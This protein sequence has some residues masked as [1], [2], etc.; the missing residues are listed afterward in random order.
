LS[1]TERNIAIIFRRRNEFELAESYCQ[2]SLSHARLYQGKEEDKIGLVCDA[3]R[4]MYGLRETQDNFIDALPFAEEAYDLVAIAYNP[5][6]PKVQKA[7]GTLIE[8]L[9]HKGDLYNAERFA[10]ATLDSLKDPAN[11]LD[12]ES[13]EVA[14]GYYNLAN[15]IDAQEGDLVKA[16]MLARESLRIRTRIYV[17]DHIEVGLSYDLLARILMSHDNLGDET[18]ELLERSL[19]VSTKNYGPDA[20]NTAI[21]NSNLGAFYHR[22]ADEQQNSQ[23]KI[24]YLFRSNSIFKEVL[25]IYSKTFGPDNPQTIEASSQISI[26]SHKLS[27]A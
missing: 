3:L 4:G 27:E 10:E 18:M 7:A 1:T 20:I 9:M 16:E 8:C 21:S 14:N 19:A 5:V 11:G 22:L 12:Q 26:I 2:Q 24:E 13:K 15:V 6:H 17:N 23:R 25:R